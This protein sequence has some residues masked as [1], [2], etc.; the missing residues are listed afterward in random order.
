MLCMYSNADKATPNVAAAAPI[1]D[2]RNCGDVGNERKLAATI[3]HACSSAF[4]HNRLNSF[5]LAP[6]VPNATISTFFFI[7]FKNSFAHIDLVGFD[8]RY[9]NVV[10]ITVSIFAIVS[11]SNVIVDIGTLKLFFFSSS[12]ISCS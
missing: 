11:L 10:K 6:S 3:T 5:G 4:V 7:A 1:A 8:T 2:A 9:S 12:H